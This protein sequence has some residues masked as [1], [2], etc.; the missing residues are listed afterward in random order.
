MLLIVYKTP[1]TI[2]STSFT[3]EPRPYHGQWLGSEDDD[4]RLH[5]CDYVSCRHLKCE[6]YGSAVYH[7]AACYQI[8]ALTS[9]LDDL[10]EHSRWGNYPPLNTDTRRI[11]YFKDSLYAILAK[12][13]VSPLPPEILV[14]IISLV[15]IST[16]SLFATEARS[17]SLSPEWKG[18]EQLDLSRKVYQQSILLEG[19]SYIR[20]L[21][22][23]SFPSSI[24]LFTPQPSVDIWRIDIAEDRLGITDI[25]FVGDSKRGEISG[26]PKDGVWWRSIRPQNN[27]IHALTDVKSRLAL[28]TRTMLIM[29]RVGSCRMSETDPL[30]IVNPISTGTDAAPQSL[31]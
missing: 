2:K 6:P 23:S 16:L 4:E 14:H 10:L 17:H 27:M 30:G 8:R 29:N 3:F 22:N 12:N 25:V 20:R 28:V 31:W 7:H 26:A 18:Y 11:S 21:S 15:P 5:F 1:E 9:P 19:M 24:L 13:T